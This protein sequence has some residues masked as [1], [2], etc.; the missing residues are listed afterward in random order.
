MVTQKRLHELFTYD[1]NIG[2]FIRKIATAKNVGVGG[3][4]GWLNPEKG[5]LFMSVDNKPYLAHRLAWL[6]VHGQ[7]PRNQIDHINHKKTDNRICNLRD[8][9]HKQNHK[10]RSKQRNNVSGITGVSWHSAASK[11]SAQIIVDTKSIH[12][13]LYSNKQ[14]AAEARRMAEQKYLF[15]HNHG[16]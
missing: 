15:H 1:P 12:L 16:K 5:Y 13:G 2:I 7:F 11:W 9:T 14:E 3:V 6:Y 4:A 8:V 10:N